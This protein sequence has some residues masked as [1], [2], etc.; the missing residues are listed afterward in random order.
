M[1]LNAF[2]IDGI[3]IF[4][5]SVISLLFFSFG[6][7]IWE[8]LYKRQPLAIEAPPSNETQ[9]D[10]DQDQVDV[11]RFRG[12]PPE[13]WSG[14]NPLPIPTPIN[15][16]IPEMDMSGSDED[17]SFHPLAT[18]SPLLRSAN[19]TPFIEAEAQIS[20]P[21]VVPVVFSEASTPVVPEVISEI[22]VP[23]IEVQPESNGTPSFSNISASSDPMLVI[24]KP[25]E[26]NQQS[27][28]T[29][30]TQ[31][32]L[33]AEGKTSS[34]TQNK[35]KANEDEAVDEEDDS[36][37][38]DEEEENSVISSAPSNIRDHNTQG[39]GSSIEVIN[40]DIHEAN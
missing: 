39:T 19:S 34:D 24:N 14:Y 30:A 22:S 2:Y 8:R 26:I 16:E 36:E 27:Q 23:M 5:C 29:V 31:N 10:Q 12:T 28:Q 17:S 37:I 21:N 11:M 18:S 20:I 13:D 25:V 35:G 40:P 1:F 38:D 6:R 33:A 9:K 7:H 32:L 3:Q 4:F 15:V